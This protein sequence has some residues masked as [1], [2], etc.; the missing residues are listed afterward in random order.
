MTALDKWIADQKKLERRASPAR[1]TL[2]TRVER[3]EHAPVP[4]GIITGCILAGERGH[5]CASEAEDQA[6]VFVEFAR[7]HLGDSSKP[8][9]H[10]NNQIEMWNAEFIAGS[11]NNYPVALAMLER[12][13]AALREAQTVLDYYGKEPGEQG[14]NA[15]PNTR[16]IKR[17]CRAALSDMER[18]AGEDK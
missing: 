5:E 3:G 13:V 1:W 17:K 9:L 16:R 8:P 11:R 2:N 12:A 6:C 18:M 7:V 15:T 4:I 14:I 10:P